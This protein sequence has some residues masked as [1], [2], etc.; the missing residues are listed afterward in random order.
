MALIK[1]YELKFIIYNIKEKE[2]RKY[3]Q[4]WEDH[5]VAPQHLFLHLSFD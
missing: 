3:L 1:I 4:T 5:D 2:K